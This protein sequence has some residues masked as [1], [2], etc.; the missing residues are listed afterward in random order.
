MPGTVRVC[1]KQQLVTDNVQVLRDQECSLLCV[2]LFVT[3]VVFAKFS[4][5]CHCF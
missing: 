5:A 4:L 1:N 3:K 2:A